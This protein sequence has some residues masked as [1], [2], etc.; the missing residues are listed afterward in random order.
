VALIVG[1]AAAYLAFKLGLVPRHL[2]GRPAD[3]T[4]VPVSQ[5]RRRPRRPPPA[6]S[7]R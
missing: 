6:A 7:E 1:V 2:R 3:V 4:I 5:L